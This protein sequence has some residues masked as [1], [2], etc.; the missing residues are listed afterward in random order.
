MTHDHVRSYR[1]SARYRERKD[2]ARGSEI[3]ENTKTTHRPRSVHF[4][5]KKPIAHAKF[6]F[7]PRKKRQDAVCTPPPPSITHVTSV[8][9][10]HAARYI[11]PTYPTPLSTRNRNPQPQNPHLR[12]IPTQNPTTQTQSTHNQTNL[13]HPTPPKKNHSEKT[14]QIT[15][16]RSP[17]RRSSRT[18]ISNPDALP[19]VSALPRHLHPIPYPIPYLTPSIG[20]NIICQSRRKDRDRA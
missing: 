17:T 9:M 5:V 1:A 4:P 6:A 2:N 14:G 16:L 19:A 15:P 11:L 18:P 20:T 8:P 10:V 7:S 13:S 3:E 12:R